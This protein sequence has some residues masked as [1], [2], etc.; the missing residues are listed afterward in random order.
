MRPVEHLAA[1]MGGLP[2]FAMLPREALDTL[3]QAMTIERHEHASAIITEGEAPDGVYLLM[4]GALE[5]VR[6][7]GEREDVLNHVLAGDLFGL[8]AIS[9]ERPRSATCRANGA[10]KLAKLPRRAHARLCASDPALAYAFSRA[11]ST[12]LARDFRALDRQIRA[13]LQRSQ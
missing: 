2:F 6:V 1:F 8:V 10:V 11:L 7:R 9:D 5:V 3:A 13:E 12:Q 4:Q